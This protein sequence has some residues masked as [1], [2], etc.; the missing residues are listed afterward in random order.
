MMSPN[1]V[2]AIAVAVLLA[3]PAEAQ[4]RKDAAIDDT[5]RDVL[6][7]LERDITGAEAKR[8]ALEQ[9]AERL[10]AEIAELDARLLAAAKAV[11]AGED[12]LS[13]LEA[14]RAEIELKEHAAME[15]LERRRGE[16]QATLAALERLGHRPPEALLAAPGSPVDALRSAMLLGAVVPELEKQAAAL[17]TSLAALARLRGDLA[18]AQKQV[19]AGGQKLGAERAA[20]DRLLAE[21]AARRSQAQVAAEAEGRRL[22]AMA[23]KV[24]DLKTLIQRLDDDARR[25][26]EAEAERQK[27]EQVRRQ[28]DGE[29]RAAEDAAAAAQARAEARKHAAIG[30]AVPMSKARGQLPLPVRGSLAGRFDESGGF[31]NRLRGI[32][33]RARPEATVTAPQGGQVAFAGEF[34]GYGQLL[35]I[36][37]GEGYHFLLAGMGRIDVA[38][39]QHVV[40]GEPVG[41]LGPEGFQRDGVRQGG[42]PELYVELRRRGEPIDPQPWFATRDSARP[43]KASG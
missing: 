26:A 21:K 12:E 34:R 14:G 37:V 29:T 8:K 15:E 25:R 17:R 32:T 13:G 18:E 9:E 4:R 5:P 10:A 22:G 16:M 24:A 38:V 28:A 30:K 27:T 3:G 43:G 39:G 23:G 33:I 41:Q 31:G 1:L 40:A 2:V 19:A 36:A 35:I 42:A 20:L 7:R 6:Q 11:Q